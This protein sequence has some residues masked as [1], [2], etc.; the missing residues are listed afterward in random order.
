MYPIT[1]R[2]CFNSS[3]AQLPTYIFRMSVCFNLTYVYAKNPISSSLIKGAAVTGVSDCSIDY[4]IAS[5]ALISFSCVLLLLYFSISLTSSSV[6]GNFLT[7]SASRRFLSSMNSSLSLAFCS[8]MYSSSKCI[9]YYERS[10]F[11]SLTTVSRRDIES[12]I[13]FKSWYP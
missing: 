1:L 5:R 3:S 10:F 13:F 6:I 11:L 12:R 7:P 2:L 9:R 4:L 8:L